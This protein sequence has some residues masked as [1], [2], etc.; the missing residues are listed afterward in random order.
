MPGALSTKLET[1]VLTKAVVAI[2]V[3][4]VPMDAVGAVATPVTSRVPDKVR[5]LNST[6]ELVPTFC[7][8]EIAP[9]VVL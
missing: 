5:S 7:P 9:L 2:W 3:V 6:S 1:A 8:M 4:F